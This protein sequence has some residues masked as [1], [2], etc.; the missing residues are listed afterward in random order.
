MKNETLCF[1][2]V[3]YI[4]LQKCQVIRNGKKSITNNRQLIVGEIRYVSEVLFLYIPYKFQL[5]PVIR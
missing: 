2:K 3:I 1:S 5:Y 4:N